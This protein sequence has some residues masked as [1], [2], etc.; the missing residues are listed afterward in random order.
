MPRVYVEDVA[1]LFF[2][3][4]TNHLQAEALNAVS[5]FPVRNRDFTRIRCSLVEL[6]TFLRIPS[7]LLKAVL[8]EQASLLLERDALQNLLD[9]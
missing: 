9:R 2:R 5:P 8:R 3:A 7:S 4:A 6:L 1:A